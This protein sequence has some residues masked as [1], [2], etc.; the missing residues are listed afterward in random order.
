MFCIFL[1]WISHAAVEQNVEYTMS[2]QRSGVIVTTPTVNRKK[3]RSDNRYT[4]CVCLWNISQ[5]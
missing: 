1:L 4:C 5:R 3:V 2:H